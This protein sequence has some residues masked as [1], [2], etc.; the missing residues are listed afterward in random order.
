MLKKKQI[1]ILGGGQAAAYAAKE[2]R[3]I[4]NHSN[5]IIVTEEKALPYERPPLSKDYLLDKIDFEKSL[6]FPQSYYDENNI[7]LKIIIITTTNF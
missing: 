3:S 2:I 4:D 1:I 6:F 5:L 7:S